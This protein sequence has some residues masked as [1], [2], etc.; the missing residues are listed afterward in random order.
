MAP[1]STALVAALGCA[2][3][4]AAAPEYVSHPDRMAAVKATFQESWDGYYKYAF[5]KDSLLP[6]SKTGEND[7]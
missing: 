2:S 3:A 7:R 4:V 1:Y 6:V 5:P